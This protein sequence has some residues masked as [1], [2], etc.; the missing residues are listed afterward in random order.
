[1]K[2]GRVKI[3]LTVYLESE[4]VEHLKVLQARTGV[5]LA[6]Y[7]RQG[8]DLVLGQNRERAIPRVVRPRKPRWG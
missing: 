1:V 4:Q 5:T 2:A 6:E 3:V 7:I 8:V